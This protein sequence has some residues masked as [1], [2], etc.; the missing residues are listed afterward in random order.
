MNSTN[1]ALIK[2]LIGFLV[3]CISF[4]GYA[5]SSLLN[6]PQTSE[7]SVGGIG[8]INSVSTNL[9]AA[10][11]APSS[12]TTNNRYVQQRPTKSTEPDKPS[13][14]EQYLTN[15]IGEKLT[16][17][18][19]ELVKDGDQSFSPSSTAAVP[20]DYL[21]AA[22]DEINVQIWG[23]VE[24]T[25]RAVV[26]RQ[27]Q[28]AI[29]KVGPV[30]VGGV[31]YANLS[32]SI[33]ETIGKT[34]SGANVAVSM[35]Q[36]RGIRVYVTGFAEVPGAYTINNL[37][38]LVNVLMAAGGPSPTGSFRDIQLKR[39]GRVI[40]HFDL[41]DLLL[42]GDKTADRALTAE[43]VIYVAP[44]GSQVAITG[45]V[46]KPAIYE[47]KPGESIENLLAYAGGF[48]SGAQTESL[49]YLG[50]DSRREGFKKISK[51]SF[52]SRVLQAGDI[53][54]ATSSIALRQP[55]DKQMRMIKVDGQ[56]NNPGI[57]VLEAGS[58]LQDAVNAA[59]GFSNDAYLFGTKLE[60]VSMKSKQTENLSRFL[61]EFRR[62][63]VGASSVK[64]TSAD[65]ASIA[66]TRQDQ[67]AN[68]LQ[69]LSE[70]KPD[71]RV[72]LGIKPNSKN[73]PPLLVE[74]GDSLTIPSVPQSVSV[75]GSINGSQ[76]G[77][78]YK[79]NQTPL[80]YIKLAGG[81]SRGADS[82]NVYLM[83]AS[84]EF[85]ST[86]SWFAGL[87]SVEVAPGDSIFVPEDL[88]KTTFTK[89]LKDWAQILSQMGLGFA[90]IKIIGQ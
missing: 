16:R 90:A 55:L 60:R 75:L 81:F 84:G 33:Q 5:Q 44:T 64:V 19:S 67:G 23:S 42:K 39:G 83:R 29:P 28:I 21:I 18:G 25:F 82:G 88:Q 41:Y 66:K 26:D 73:L 20:D 24:G 79:P 85:V 86:S 49:N 70:I 45:A 11:S 40:S 46:N 1:K 3:M 77:L 34:Y 52:T 6:Q 13:D 4:T 78:A 63:V 2:I 14:F 54:L 8:A 62:D 76:V 15:I 50:L 27:G 69:A 51:N 32:K 72:A 31:T 36:M 7:A 87:G 35:G 59:G 71:G 47:V 57:Y 12:G 61:V 17:F 22:G 65:D 38:S 80:D 48:A 68:M 30:R 53:Y 9:N 56:V 74:S 43:D 10:G 37:S 89:E 58:T